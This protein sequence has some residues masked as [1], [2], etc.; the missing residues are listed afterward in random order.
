MIKLNKN[1]LI[2]RDIAAQHLDEYRGKEQEL[3]ANWRH[4]NSEHM[5][6]DAMAR[7]GGYEFVD[8]HHWDNSDYS[9]TKTATI[10]YNHVATV[11]GILSDRARSPKGGDLRVVLYNPVYDRLDYYFMPKAGWENIREYGVANCDRL[12]ASYNADFDV[13]H[14]WKQWRVKDFE[15]L[16]RMP[17][18]VA[19]PNTF[20]PISNFF[21]LFAWTDDA[22]VAV[23]LFPDL[24]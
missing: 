14:K 22:D 1:Q 19:A 9:D 21:D 10:G 7:V 2:L 5:V 15:T 24:D 6:E 17:A 12:R 20:T 3:L 23:D 11:T 18:T 4:Y 16:A 8:A 13:I